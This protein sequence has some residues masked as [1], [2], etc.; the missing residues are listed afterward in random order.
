MSV[1]I[2]EVAEIIHRKS[3]RGEFFTVKW[4]DGVNTTVKLAKGEQSDVYTA[5]VYAVGKRIFPDKGYARNYI[6][7]KK[8]VFDDRMKQKSYEKQR[9]RKEMAL[10]QSLEARCGDIEDYIID[11]VYEDMFVAPALISRSVFRRNR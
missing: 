3:N 4:T 7:S 1:I 10:Q 5:F 11:K 2:P 9:K 6:E 8:K